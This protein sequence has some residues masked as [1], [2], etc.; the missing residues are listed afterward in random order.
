MGH[1]NTK[2]RILDAALEL[3]AEKSYHEVSL[4][5]IARKA[6]V[7]KGGLFHY[8][9]SKYDLA[10]EV[11]FREAERIRKLVTAMLREK[12]S[13]EEKL[14][15]LVDSSLELVLENPKL[16]R[17]YLEVYEEAMKRGNGFDEWRELARDYLRVIAG[18]FEE[19]GAEKPFERAML[20]AALL[21]G[22]A[23]DYLLMGGEVDA[24]SLKDEILRLFACTPEK[25][26]HYPAE[27]SK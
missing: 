25:R 11:L 6:G 3:F 18:V 24:E 13:L 7:S 8:F 16:S 14:R 26:R 9:P 20:F 4:D 22:I 2:N 17:F 21:D 12:A 5:E 19:M 10:K 23:I 1:K 15:L 27:D